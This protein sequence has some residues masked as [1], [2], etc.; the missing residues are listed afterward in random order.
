[1]IDQATTVRRGEELNLPQLA[2]YLTA[3]LPKAQ[4]PLT[5]EQFPSGY[6]N[7]TYLLRL[8]AQEL[9]LRRPP[10]GANIQ[11]AHDMGREY[12]VLSGLIRVYPKVPR[13]LLYCDDPSILGAPFYVME[14]VQGVI[15]RAGRAAEIRFPSETIRTLSSVFIRNLAAIHA[16]DLTAAGLADLGRPSGYV[17][18]Q[19]SGWTR[20]YRNAQTDD[21][22]SLEAAIAWLENHQ[23][24]ES[25]AAIIH[26][27][28]KYDNVVLAPEDLTQLVAVLDWEMCTIGDPLLDLGTTLGYWI[29]LDDPPALQGMFGLTTLPGNLNRRQLVEE[30]EAASGREIGDPLF[31]YV[32]GLF[33]IGVIIQQIYARYRQGH[34]QDERFAGLFAVVQGCGEMIERALGRGQIS[35]KVA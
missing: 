26:N 10:F 11:S 1:M 31:Y 13:P 34:T 33:K 7:L 17:A 29:E 14:R 24:A 16:L 8:G 4:G 15:L 22:P 12:R 21:V 2:A 23:P 18:R 5:V 30:Y 35:A 27:D 28:Y 3:H 19:I 9:V 6:S 32:Y 25:G 20:R